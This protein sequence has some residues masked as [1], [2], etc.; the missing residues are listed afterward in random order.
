MK[1]SMLYGVLLATTLSLSSLINTSQAGELIGNA[2]YGLPLKTLEDRVAELEDHVDELV[3]MLNYRINSLASAFANHKHGYTDCD[4]GIVWR[5]DLNG[6]LV[7][8]LSCGKRW[9][10]KPE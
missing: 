1:R 7:N 10:G 9:T 3:A 4:T 6:Y 2:S 5:E 8:G